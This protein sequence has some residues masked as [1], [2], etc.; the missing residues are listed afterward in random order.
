MS[1]GGWGCS[2]LLEVWSII[3]K[4]VDEVVEGNEVWAEWVDMGKV[5]SSLERVKVLGVKWASQ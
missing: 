5:G 1:G 2:D 4:V 3:V